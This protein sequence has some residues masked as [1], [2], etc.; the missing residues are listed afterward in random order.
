M[1]S[2]KQFRD[3]A[4]GAADLFNYAALVDEGLVLCK[5]GSLLAGFFYRGP[6][7]QSATPAEL[8]YLTRR[9]NAALAKLGAGFALWVDAVRLPTAGY[10]EASAS[11]FPDA[12]TRT[13][14]EERR[15]QFLAEGAHFETEYALLVS[16]MPPLRRTQRLADIVYD[17]DP[18][19]QKKS[20]GD[21]QIEAFK[22]SLAEIEDGLADVLKLRRMKGFRVA[23]ASGREHLRD[24]LLNYLQFVITGELSP[25]NVPPCAMYLD[26]LLGGQDVAEIQQQLAPTADV[27]HNVFLDGR[28]SGVKRQID[29]LVRENIGQYEINIIIDC[30]DYS[31]PV[32]VK[33]VEEFDGLL[34]DVGAQKGVLVCPRGFTSTA[35]KRAEG[36]QIDLYS[37]IDTDAHKWQA[38]VTIPALCDFRNARVD[39]GLRFS[40]PYPFRMPYDFYSDCMIFDKTSKEA[41]HVFRFQAG[42]GSDL[43]PATFCGVPVGRDE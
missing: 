13:I 36:L 22:R 27:L 11:F 34:R 8:N 16:Y 20:P 21:R 25:V 33:G 12:A 24:E 32:D 14:D 4:K 6:D 3:R 26:A 18:Q 40:A 30:K 7:S 1:L 43:M 17:D 39:F 38:R 23:D 28:S 15:R 2:L 9:L 10:P 37:P 31:T 35:K 41:G 29:V 5:D 19:S 42:R